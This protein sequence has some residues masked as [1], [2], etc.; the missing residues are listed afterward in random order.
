MTAVQNMNQTPSRDPYTEQLA[1]DEAAVLLVDHQVGMFASVRDYTVAELKHNLV[2]LVRAARELGVPIVAT[3]VP[4]YA[5]GPLVPELAEALPDGAPIIERTIVNAWAEPAVREAIEATGR[6][7]LIIAG[8]TTEVCLILPALSAQR[9]GHQV[10][11]VVDASGSNDQ[12]RRT[13]AMLRMQQAGVIVSD[14][15][16]LGVEMLGDNASPIAGQVYGALDMDWATLN[17][18]LQAGYGADG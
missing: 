12:T 1:P 3:K 4:D 11:A 2:A 10:Y 18:Q 13:I 7:K 5:M 14:H 9:A 17:G 8:T 15:A 16:T 6:S